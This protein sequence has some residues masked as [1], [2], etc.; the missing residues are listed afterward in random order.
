[1]AYRTSAIKIKN[2]TITQQNRTTQTAHKKKTATRHKREAEQIYIKE[3]EPPKN[4]R[5]I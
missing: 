5:T 4:D 2:E 3:R 1:M